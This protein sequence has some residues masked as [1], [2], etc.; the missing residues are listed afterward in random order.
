MLDPKLLRENLTTIAEGLKR[1]GAILPEDKLSALEIQRKQL[2]TDT[3][4]LQHERNAS[5]KTIGQ[6]KARGEA[7]EPLL[8]AVSELG[9]KLDQKSEALHDVQQQLKNLQLTFPNLPHESVPDGK[10][11]AHNVEIRKWGEPKVFDFEARDHVDLGENLS[12]MDFP[13]AAKIAGSR[14]V[15]LKNQLAKLQ[16]AIG[17]FMLNLHTE[18]HGYHEMYVPYLVNENSLYGTSQLPKFL[19]DQF[20]VAGEHPYF[21]NPTGEVP[22]TNLVRDVIVDEVELP[23]KLVAQTPC[24][25]REAGSYGKDT[26]GMIRQHQFEKVELVWI[27]KPEDS[28]HALEELTKHAETVLQKLALPYRVMTLCAGDMGFAAAKTYDLEV[29]LPGQAA[30]REIS[31]CSNCEDFQAR[32]MHARFRPAGGGKPQLVHTL[33]GSGLAIGRT[34]VAVLENYQMADGSIK[35]PEVLQPYMGLDIIKI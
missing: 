13:V 11:E 14:F 17:Q 9:D 21:L 29:W 22:L 25:R 18:A 2:Q 7:I 20:C 31:S 33:N 35:I 6:A 1:R 10:D 26:R 34:L 15:V 32:R 12:Q 28:Y 3:E 30:Y 23:L 27:V 19:D 5:A 24:F 16:R 8:A 4:A